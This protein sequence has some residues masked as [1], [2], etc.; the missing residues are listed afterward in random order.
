MNI[1]PSVRALD[2]SIR[3]RTLARTRAVSLGFS[4]LAGSLGASSPFEF[5][6]EVERAPS[7][8]ATS[9]VPGP[10]DA[11]G[12]GVANGAGSLGAITACARCRRG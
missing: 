6:G 10:V 3:R 8:G 7:G 9:W 1:A 2:M 5:S 12:C 11:V 4:P